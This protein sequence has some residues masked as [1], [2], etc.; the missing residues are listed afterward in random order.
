MAKA[1]AAQGQSTINQK[2]VVIAAK[3]VMVAVE[4]AAAVAV[5]VATATV[6]M[7]ATMWQPWQR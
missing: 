3:M 1:E 6:A 7:E 2:A 5:A 4:M